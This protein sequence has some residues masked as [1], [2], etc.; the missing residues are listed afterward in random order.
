MQILV[1]GGAG[2]IGG[3]IAQ[4]VVEDG[5][6]VTVLDN[7]DPYYDVGI[8]RHTIDIC[9]EAAQASDGSYEFVEGDVRDADLVDR[10]VAEADVVYHQAAQAGVRTSVDEPRKPNEINVDGTL[11]VLDAARDGEIE[12]VVLASSSSVYGKPE[13]LP[14]DEDHPTT[15][16]SPYGVSK[17]AGEQYARVYNE[18][19]GL[20]T[21]SLRYFTVYGPRMRP[22]MAIS[23]FVSRCTN[24]KPPVV[25]GDGSQTRD[26]T[27]I[28]DIVDVNRTLMTD[29]SADGEILNVGSTGNIDIHTLAEV[30]RD[31]IDPSLELEYGEQP[32]GDAQ[33]THADVSKA[34]E[35]LG[36]E[37]STEIREGVSQF[38]DWYQDNRDWYEPLVLQS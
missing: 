19:Y 32:T 4:S 38:I 11:N 34:T 15:P 16:V 36:Y 10:L 22:N 1:T 30:I 7:L 37:P 20:P 8:K 6:D 3:H 18:V 27:F 28:E 24:G 31:E 21:V 13:Y 23:N 26:F 35:L 25:Y 12:R 29:D 14:Y 5:H 9:R 17:L 2:F 33:H